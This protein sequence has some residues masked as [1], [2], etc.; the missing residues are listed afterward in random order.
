VK[1][2]LPPLHIKLGL[3]KNDVKAMKKDGPVFL[4]LQ[5]K[6]PR[7]SEAKIKKKGFLSY[8]GK[9]HLKK[10]CITVVREGGTWILLGFKSPLLWNF[11]YSIG[12][13]FI[14]RINWFQ[15]F[16]FEQTCLETAAIQY[17]TTSSGQICLSHYQTLRRHIAVYSIPCCGLARFIAT[18]PAH[19]V[20]DS[21]PAVFAVF[22]SPSR[23]VTASSF[24]P[25]P[26]DMPSMAVFSSDLTL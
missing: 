24:V 16:L 2:F 13:L 6:F 21:K 23:R 4:N 17:T 5:Q 8:T 26:H 15:E 14:S 22:R 1:V 11:L 3:V 25:L 10:L 12:S 19:L 20:L 7:L 18:E 9:Q